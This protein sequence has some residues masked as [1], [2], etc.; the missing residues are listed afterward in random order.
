M[1]VYILIGIIFIVILISTRSTLNESFENF[2]TGNYQRPSEVALGTLDYNYFD[3]WGPSVNFENKGNSFGTIG[4]FPAIPLCDQ[5]HLGVN[6]PNYTFTD[7]ENVCHVC[8]HTNAN[9]EDLDKPLYVNARAAGRPRQCRQIM[10][11]KK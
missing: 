6:C 1:L 9:Y 7:Q 11:Y 8:S 4:T 3:K 10:N 2:A 5:C